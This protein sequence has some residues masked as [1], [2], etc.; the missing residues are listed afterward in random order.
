MIKNGHILHKNTRF[1]CVI[2]PQNVEKLVKKHADF[3]TKN[4]EESI[5]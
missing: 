1:L 5:Y 2:K 3:P 4:R